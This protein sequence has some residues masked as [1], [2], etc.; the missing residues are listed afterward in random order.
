MTVIKWKWHRDIIK[1][2]Q[3][4][5]IDIW[6]ATLEIDALSILECACN[7]IELHLEIANIWHLSTMHATCSLRPPH[8]STMH[9][10]VYTRSRCYG[11][12]INWNGQ[13]NRKCAYWM[14]FCHS[15]SIYI[16]LA[17]RSLGARVFF[18]LSLI[19]YIYSYE[20][21]FHFTQVFT[22]AKVFFSI[23]GQHFNG[24]PVHFSYMPDTVMENA[25]DV[26]IKLHHRIGKYVQ[27]HL[28]F[29]LRWIM[30][31]EVTFVTGK[32]LEKH[33]DCIHT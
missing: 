25:R 10:R 5:C 1:W 7:F 13:L 30:L 14:R 28:Y 8:H 6:Q 20:F 4:E 22:H 11:I 32:P 16:K 3:F 21:S 27:V 15:I 9:V 17:F 31:S 33:A 26:T 24:E 29:A 12:A 2:C 23:G 18:Y 19:P